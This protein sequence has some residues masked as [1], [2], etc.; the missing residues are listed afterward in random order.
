MLE[1]EDAENPFTCTVT[2]EDG[3]VLGDDDYDVTRLS[4]ETAILDQAVTVTL[5]DAVRDEANH[6][7]ALL[8]WMRWGNMP[9]LTQANSPHQP[10]GAWS[11]YNPPTAL[12]LVGRS[13]RLDETLA[14]SFRAPLNDRFDSPVSPSSRLYTFACGFGDCQELEPCVL[15]SANEGPAAPEPKRYSMCP[16]QVPSQPRVW[17]SVFTTGMKRTWYRRTGTYSAPGHHP[18][19]TGRCGP[20]GL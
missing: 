9:S 13:I 18:C 1:T 8:Q 10:A 20:T 19:T 4:L 14:I 6:F 16:R 12:R 3:Q 7:V 17:W 15:T 11:R 2:A 5:A